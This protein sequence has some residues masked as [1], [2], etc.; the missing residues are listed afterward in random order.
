MNVSV[1]ALR[2]N[3]RGVQRKAEA[4]DRIRRWTVSLRQQPRVT[5]DDLDVLVEAVGLEGGDLATSPYVFVDLELD[6]R[7]QIS[8]LG[9]AVHVGGEIVSAG[10]GVTELASF[11]K[12]ITG[13]TVVAHNGAAHDFPILTAAGVPL[14]PCTDSLR[15]SW[16]AWPTA[17]SHSLGSLT[18]QQLRDFELSELHTAAG[19]AAAL[20]GLWL[21]LRQSLSE[22][23]PA[24]RAR[25]RG[26]LSQIEPGH[27]L[28]DLFAPTA[29]QPAPG[30]S[31]HWVRDSANPGRFTSRVVHAEAIDSGR[32]GLP[33]DAVVVVESLTSALKRSPSAG[34]LARPAD[35]LD[36]PKVEGATGWPRAIADRLLEAARGCIALG[37]PT[38]RPLLA[39]LCRDGADPLINEGTPLLA[40]LATATIAQLRRHLVLD[41]PLGRLFEPISTGVELSGWN[42]GAPASL[43]DLGED[44]RAQ[45]IAAL[46]ESCPADLRPLADAGAGLLVPS[47][48]GASWMLPPLDPGLHGPGVTLVVGP[49]VGGARSRTMWRHLLG[50]DVEVV[51]PEQARV[52][53]TA[54]TGLAASSRG[55]P[56]RRTAQLLAV[57]AAVEQRGEVALV[58]DGTDHRRAVAP[59]AASLWRAHLHRPLL[60]PPDWPTYEEARRRIET[61]TASTALVGRRAAQRLAPHA[62]RVLLARA[63][64]PGTS[65]PTMRRL[66]ESAKHDA[67]GEVV[68]PLSAH[69]AAE[70]A[71]HAN[72]RCVIADPILG[73][74]LLAEL[75]G[76]PEDLDL[77]ELPT[78]EVILNAVLQ[79]L[80]ASEGPSAISPDGIRAATA[81]LI[82]RDQELRDFQREVIA[83]VVDGRDVLAVFRTGRGKSLC[84]QVPALAAAA[85][86]GST[87]VISP[88][89][90][91]QRD[92]LA[93]LRRRGVFEAAIYN[94][95]LS[96]EV[97]AGIRRGLVAGFYRVLFL[98]P[99]ALGGH[100]IRNALQQTQVAILAIDEA[101]CISEMGHDFRPDYRTLPR[102][103]CRMLSLPDN[104]PLPEPG[105]RPVLL[106]LTGTATPAVIDDVRDMLGG[107]FRTHVDETFVRDELR[108][109][110]TTVAG[111]ELPQGGSAL[112]ARRPER[113]RA[114]LKTLA[115]TKSPTIIYAATQL[116]TEALAG[117][118]AATLEEQVVA[119]HGGLEDADRRDAE[120]RFLSGECDFIVA[121]SAFGMGVDKADVRT[122]IHWQLPKSP[123]ALY[124]EAGRAGRGQQG[125]PAQ[126]V[127]LFHDADADA[128]YRILRRGVPTPGEIERAARALRELANLQERE[129]VHVTD[130][131]LGRLALLRPDVEPRVVLAHLERAGLVREVDRL[132]SARAYRVR[133]DAP[134]DLTQLERD[135]VKLLDPEG[136]CTGVAARSFLGIGGTSNPRQVW[137]AFRGMERRGVIA[138]C[139]SVSAWLLVENPAATIA[140]VRRAALHVWSTLE[141]H[142]NSKG[143]KAYCWSVHKGWGDIDQLLFGLELLAAFGLIEVRREVADGSVPAVRNT[144]LSPDRLGAA[145]KNANPLVDALRSFEMRGLIAV[146]QLAALTG[147]NEPELMDALTLLH[148]VGVAAVDL[149]SW[150]GE[151]ETRKDRVVRVVRV[152][153]DVDAEASLAGALVASKRRAREAWLKLE[154]LRRYALIETDDEEDGI[155]PHQR[156]LERYLTERDF[157]EEV[158]AKSTA[159]LLDR[160]APGQLAAVLAQP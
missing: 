107:H 126:A 43:S 13:R 138:R 157:L 48:R 22:L 153:P 127:L 132:H 6:A 24:T 155:D 129:L 38:A 52:E 60:R 96:E 159:D 35:V 75:I 53:W 95:D 68:E 78:N 146:D 1:D 108:F 51:G 143:K 72:G 98:A 87:V 40:D 59:L 114:V 55:H 82:G 80:L 42:L 8:E 14:G 57:A 128:A 101:H 160:L 94:S 34:V 12:L 97:R 65:Q 152:L 135:I 154:T 19:D 133:R 121:T 84:Y 141:A 44:E 70:L 76:P 74:G 115:Q 136:G 61:G 148:F 4:R 64:L 130:E 137:Q 31:P 139:R 37:P 92:Q 63:P 58:V 93:A 120:D 62:H 30:F 104:V 16:L 79:Q 20:A 41:L 39:G 124:Q 102:E 125:Q 151:G 103:I 23:A 100:G 67:F 123:D 91:L 90:A 149:R 140:D 47:E 118:L 86:D 17:E 7:E 109:S 111:E 147:L 25:L 5:F 85:R 89:V 145:F 73:T 46:A 88:L 158:A 119:Y 18:A 66:L 150:E 122:V 10:G 49:A 116:E 81:R 110:V 3:I 50:K 29:E 54:L 33:E 131:D 11:A 45:S 117:E 26:S 56:G 144:E 77:S 9:A 83:D 99:E 27:V 113:W 106:A 112:A 36:T 69:L 2:R 28:D 32:A 105:S 21:R 71:V 15:W 134:G 142:H 156:F